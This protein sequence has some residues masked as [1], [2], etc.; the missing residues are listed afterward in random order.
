[1]YQVQSIQRQV[2]RLAACQST[3]ELVGYVPYHADLDIQA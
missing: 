2:F 1:M 3:S